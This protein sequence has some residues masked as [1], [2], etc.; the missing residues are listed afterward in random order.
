MRLSW[1]RVA[2]KS[3]VCLEEKGRQYPEDGGR[4]WRDV[5]IDQGLVVVPRG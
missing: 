2:L 5:S 1:F 3:N 4:D